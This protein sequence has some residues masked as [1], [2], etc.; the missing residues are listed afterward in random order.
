MQ[1]LT[2]TLASD[3]VSADQSRAS[4]TRDSGV[5]SAFEVA[6]EF[7]SALQ[8]AVD[9]WWIRLPLLSALGHVNVYAI[10]ERDG[11]TLVDT[12]E[13]TEQCRAAWQVLLRD[14]PLANKPVTRVIVTH[15]HPD[16]IGLAGWFAERGAAIHSTRL[17]WLYGRM[18]QMD[19]HELPCEEQ[20]R[21]AE[22]AG[23]KGM[24]LAAFRRR[25]PSH[26]SQLVAPVPFS[27][28]RL[29][30][31]DVC[32]IGRRR[33]T[34]HVGNGHAAGHAT[35]WSED[36]LA[37]TGDQILPGISSNLSVHASEPDADLVSE[38]L[39][40]CQRL[41]AVASD[42]TLCLPGHNLPFVGAAT[43]CE[44]L[45]ANL[46]LV[47]KRLLQRLERPATAVECLE[48]V[49]RRQLEGHE[50]LTLIAETVGFL[51][52]LKHQ[53]LVRRELGRDGSH[54]WRLMRKL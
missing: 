45:I 32:E 26:F 47:L 28:V 2:P 4:A 53:G 18:L 50:Q 36:G 1:Q 41:Q 17:C 13:N 52:H 9:I 5:Q 46:D 37:L 6:P 44:Q 8:V 22:R 15:Y 29:E 19:D 38:W 33:W 20:I 34:V 43:R 12:G 11:W 31:D 24:A 35:L 27:Y 54:I 10:E 7:G 23:V 49:Y 40:S 42:A 21:F 39:E 14:G 25:R 16:H 30:Q 48:A 51:N 3:S